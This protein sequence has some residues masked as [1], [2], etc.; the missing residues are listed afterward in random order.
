MVTLLAL[1]TNK[2]K[3]FEEEKSQPALVSYHLIILPDKD[4]Y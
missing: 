2:Q 1:T 3:C 4:I